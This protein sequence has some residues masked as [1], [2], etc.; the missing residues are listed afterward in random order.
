MFRFPYA[1]RHYYF[2]RGYAY[3]ATKAAEFATKKV[4]KAEIEW[5]VNYCKRIPF[6]GQEE[7]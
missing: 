4:S 7:K 3:A 5:F 2:Q 6:A 1:I